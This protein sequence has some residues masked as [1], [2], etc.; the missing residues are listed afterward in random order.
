MISFGDPLSPDPLTGACAARRFAGV[1]GMNVLEVAAIRQSTRFSRLRGGRAGSPS[2]K[3]GKRSRLMTQHKHLKQL[4]VFAFHYE[5][6]N[7]ST[8]FVAGRHLWQ[9]DV[10]YT[11]AACERVGLVSTFQSRVVRLGPSTSPV[12]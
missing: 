1:K 8:F 9:D 3:A 2:L 12:W 5:K 4:G 6:E 11:K 7:F 10:A